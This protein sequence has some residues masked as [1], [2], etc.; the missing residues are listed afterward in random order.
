MRFQFDEK[1][2]DEKIDVFSFGNNIYA[3][4]TGLW[5]FYDISD[6]QVTQEKLTDG[7]LPYIDPRWKERSYIERRLVELMEKC[8]IFDP[9]ERVDIFFAVE[10]LKETVRE[11]NK[12]KTHNSY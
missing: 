6:D 5:G 7:D 12:L 2:L 10:F 3:M 9:D 8:W 4:L 1:D 11:Y